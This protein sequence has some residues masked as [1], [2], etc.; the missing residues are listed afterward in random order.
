[1]HTTS[2][3]TSDYAESSLRNSLHI[4]LGRTPL[5]WCLC[6]SQW[7]AT[8]SSK[9]QP[10]SPAP[11]AALLVPVAQ[12]T[13]RIAHQADTSRPKPRQDG[14]A[15]MSCPTTTHLVGWGRGLKTTCPPFISHVPALPFMQVPFC[16]SVLIL[17]FLSKDLGGSQKLHRLNR[18]T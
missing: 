2:C 6:S 1:M 17:R 8:R 14:S 7:A 10:N 5:R 11:L 3:L 18:P 9:Y 12:T 15:P 16:G 13:Q 4:G